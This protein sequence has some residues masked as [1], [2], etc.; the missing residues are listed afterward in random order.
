MP[1]C[2]IQDNK[3]IVKFPLISLTLAATADLSNQLTQMLHSKTAVD[4]T[5]TIHSLDEV[6][7][8]N[9]NYNV[10]SKC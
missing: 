2:N 9:G 5:I 1:I 6:L 10:I 7:L 3:K 8:N 4:Y